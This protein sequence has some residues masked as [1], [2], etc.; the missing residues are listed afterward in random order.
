MKTGNCVR[1]K[2]QK[3]KHYNLKGVA[4]N[5]AP[6]FT[7][8]KLFD[9]NEVVTF[10]NEALEPTT[11]VSR[12]NIESEVLSKVGIDI[13]RLIREVKA[14]LKATELHLEHSRKY[15]TDWAKATVKALEKE[16][17]DKREI[18][19]MLNDLIEGK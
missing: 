14:M 3:S 11:H 13:E 18:I 19:Q 17:Q 16:L 2:N 10:P 12:P 7:T 15:Q 9:T 5:A 4:I 6:Q 1:V 8:V